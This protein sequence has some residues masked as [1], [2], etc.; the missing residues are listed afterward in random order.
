LKI[1]ITVFRNVLHVCA[2][3]LEYFSQYCGYVMGWTVQGSIPGN[4]SGFYL[5]QIIHTG[6]RSNPASYSGVTVGYS[7]QL[8]YEPNNSHLSTAKGKE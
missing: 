1:G 4:D 7:T 5:L 2:E 8:M 3:E 6:F